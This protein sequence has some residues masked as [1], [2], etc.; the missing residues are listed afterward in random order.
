MADTALQLK[1]MQIISRSNIKV[2]WDMGLAGLPNCSNESEFH[3]IIH[4]LPSDL[5][6]IL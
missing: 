4:V 5:R 1:L 3:K 2:S 6:G